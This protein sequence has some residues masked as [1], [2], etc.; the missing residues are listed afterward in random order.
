MLCISIIAKLSSIL[1][2]F[3]S[4]KKYIYFFHFII[5]VSDKRIAFFPQ[6]GIGIDSQSQLL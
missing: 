2:P 3:H 4:F 1:F 5:L 6:I